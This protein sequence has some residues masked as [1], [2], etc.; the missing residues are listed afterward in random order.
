MRQEVIMAG[1]GGQ[2]IMF[3]G[4]VLAQAAMEENKK[5]T[6][7]PS[8]GAEMRG[9][10]ANCTVVISDEDIGSPI[11][12]NPGAVIAMNQ[13]STNKFSQKLK[14]SGLLIMDSSLAHDE[15]ENNQI[16]KVKIE[17]TRIADELGDKRVANMVALGAYLKEIKILKL[18]TLKKA[19][20]HLLGEKKKK[21]IDINIKALEKGYGD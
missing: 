8:Y 19:L 9:G 16:R 21:L 18:D 14:K 17:A 20:T 7:F 13:Q 2:G 1:F 11:V 5:V 6:F 15:P 10:V 12:A 4:T 3:M